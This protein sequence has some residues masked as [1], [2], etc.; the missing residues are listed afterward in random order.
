V[1]CGGPRSSL[2]PSPRDLVLL[3]DPSLVLE[4]DFYRFA[5]HLSFGEPPGRQRSLWNGQ[6]RLAAQET[7][8]C[9]PPLPFYHGGNNREGFDFGALQA[10][11]NAVQTF[12]RVQTLSA[13]G[14]VGFLTHSSAAYHFGLYDRLRRRL[15]AKLGCYALRALG[16]IAG[17]VLVSPVFRSICAICTEL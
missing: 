14:G 15:P 3:T 9:V 1:G 4:P 16:Q 10:L 6:P 11:L 12:Q 17:L 2:G 13:G 5:S 7:T 8:I